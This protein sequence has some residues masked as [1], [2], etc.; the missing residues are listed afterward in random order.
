MRQTINAGSNSYNPNNIGGGCPFQAKMSEGGFTSHHER[1]EGHKV[2]TR[3]QS[4]MDHYSQAKLFYQSQSEVE[5]EHI[6]EALQFELGKLKM[7][8]IRE[9]MVGILTYI[10]MQLAQAVAKGLGIDSI[11]EPEKPI[12]H[13]YPA[14]ADPADYQSKE[15]KPSVEKSE[16]LSL[17]ASPGK[18]IKGRIIA[19][20]ANDGVDVNSL[21][22]YKKAL[23]DAKAEAKVISVHS[24]SITGAN[25][26][27]IMVDHSLLT[28]SS[29]LFDAVLVPDGEASIKSFKDNPSAIRFLDESYK[30]LKFMAIN[31]AGKELWEQTYASKNS[32]PLGVF[33]D[34][35]IGTFID[36]IAK[37]RAWDR[38]DAKRIPV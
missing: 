18:G 15:A 31:G 7:I 32:E 36:S 8:Q 34:Q 22:S 19:I 27:K 16:K 5:Q 10:D 29:V 33:F 35:E 17:M 23:K 3:S 13:G 1:V 28:T 20:L 24:G 30:H 38:T 9:R 2:R 21:N 6:I 14:D 26:E 11:K 12:N 37:H 4:F 25:G